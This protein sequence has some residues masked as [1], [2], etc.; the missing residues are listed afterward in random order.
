MGKAISYSA[1]SLYSSDIYTT[2]VALPYGQGW[3]PDLHDIHK[4]IIVAFDNSYNFTDIVVKL[5]EV[6]S[7]RISTS[8]DNVFWD[9]HPEVIM[10]NKHCHCHKAID[11]FKCEA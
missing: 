11:K 4:Y 1:S 2:D 3:V 5:R 10:N 7:F 8:E 6:H 9:I